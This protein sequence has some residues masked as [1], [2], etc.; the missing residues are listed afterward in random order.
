MLG[1]TNVSL[2]GGKARMMLIA[3]LDLPVGAM[4]TGWDTFVPR[5]GDP[6]VAVAFKRTVLDPTQTSLRAPAARA[7]VASS[8]TKPLL[9]FA[10]APERQTQAPVRL[11]LS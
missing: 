5:N 8:P 6:V 9:I 11:D 2:T 1:A 7:T 10:L 3:S 4:A